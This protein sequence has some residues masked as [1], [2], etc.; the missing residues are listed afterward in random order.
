MRFDSVPQALAEQNGRKKFVQQISFTASASITALATSDEYGK[1][2][3]PGAMLCLQATADCLYKLQP[4]SA[5]S[6]TVTVASGAHP[7]I[8]IL[9]NQQE[10]TLTHGDGGM[11]A[12]SWGPDT[13]IEVIGASGSGKLNIWLVS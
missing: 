8:Y 11:N 2:V 6:A 10:F 3:P 12:S 13:Q 9:A 7:G 1:A 4:A 5:G